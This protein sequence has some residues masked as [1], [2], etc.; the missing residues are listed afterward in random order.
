M[1]EER[2]METQLFSLDEAAQHGLEGRT[3]RILFVDEDPDFLDGLK[4]LLRHVPSEWQIS[5]RTTARDALRELDGHDF[6][7]IVTGMRLSD[8][9]ARELLSEVLRHHP[10]VVRIAFCSG[11]QPELAI[12]TANPAHQ[13]LMVPCDAATLRKTLEAAFRIRKMLVS[14]RLKTLI[15]RITSLPSLPAVHDKLIA[16]LNDPEITSRGLGEIIAQDVRP[17]PPSTWVWIPFGR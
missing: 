13:Y 8:M 5:F 16:S 1:A 15:S 7:A 11:M 14:P 12:R 2:T 6:D 4:A 9:C 17:K 10:L 3:K